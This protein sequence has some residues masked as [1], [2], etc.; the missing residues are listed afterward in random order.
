MMKVVFLEQKDVFD[1]QE[2]A[3]KGA[4]K[5]CDIIYNGKFSGVNEFNKTLLEGMIELFKCADK[6]IKLMIVSAHGEPLTST[7]LDA[8]NSEFID[9]YYLNQYFEVVPN[10]LI[11]YLNVCFGLYPSSWQLQKATINKPI[12]IAPLVDIRVD[13]ANQIQDEL[14]KCLSGENNFESAILKLIDRYNSS[15]YMSAYANRIIIGCLKKDGSVYPNGFEG[16]LCAPVYG[17]DIFKIVDLFTPGEKEQSGP[18]HHTNCVLER[19]GEKYIATSTRLYD[20][21][22]TISQLKNSYIKIKY[23]IYKDSK[24]HNFGRLE[25]VNK[26]KLKRSKI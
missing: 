16:Q 9:W 12:L 21:A 26:P 2:T 22:S 1:C 17:P 23:Q 13:H 11:I 10:N 25:I 24:D 19:N 20:I 3:F 18:Y 8:G 5:N 4:V 6:D 14:I 7:Q 15:N